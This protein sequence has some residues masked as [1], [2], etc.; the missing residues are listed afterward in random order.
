VDVKSASDVSKAVDA[1]SAKGR[2]SVLLR[3]DGE[4]G[5]RFVALPVGKG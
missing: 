2:K 5:S 1:A 4:N 3:V